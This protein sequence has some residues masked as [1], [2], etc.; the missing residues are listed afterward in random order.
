[1]N[2]IR[3]KRNLKGLDFL[4]AFDN[5]PA[6]FTYSFIKERWDKKKNLPS[7]VLKA[8]IDPTTMLWKDF[9]APD[10]DVLAKKNLTK[11]MKP[12]TNPVK[13]SLGAE[14]KLES[15]EG[16]PMPGESKS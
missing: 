10:P 6:S 9:A 1:M 15:A 8:H 14:I 7:S 2:K 4:R 13:T 11:E 3:K 5:M 16:V 12:R